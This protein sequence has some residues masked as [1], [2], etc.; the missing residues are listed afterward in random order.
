MSD[1]FCWVKW[2][3]FHSQLNAAS[4]GIL[5]FK[6]IYASVQQFK[7]QRFLRSEP[8][9]LH[10]AVPA[11]VGCM[12]LC[13][14]GDIGM[15]LHITHCFEAE[16]SMGPSSEQLLLLRIEPLLCI[17]RISYSTESAGKGCAAPRCLLWFMEQQLSWCSHRT[18]A[19]SSALLWAH[20][21]SFRQVRREGNITSRS[22]HQPP[23]DEFKVSSKA[24]KS[25]S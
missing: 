3:D 18:A 5:R 11:Q 8:W 10:T 13:H 14:D 19:F 15:L 24:R 23:P 2:Q 4:W 12:S 20:S 17:S 21:S 1:H 9:S 22:H 7:N 6:D 25:N 16:L